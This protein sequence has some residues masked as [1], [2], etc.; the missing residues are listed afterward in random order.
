MRELRAQDST[1]SKKKKEKN[2]LQIWPT[3]EGVF[4]EC[5]EFYDKSDGATFKKIDQ[6]QV[7]ICHIGFGGP[8]WSK[9]NVPKI[10]SIKS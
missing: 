10:Q 9:L 3:L 2:T 1:V 5:R 4:V 7:A 8:A 6:F